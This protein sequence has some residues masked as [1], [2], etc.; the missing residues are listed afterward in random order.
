MAKKRK[1]KFVSQAP[2]QKD[3]G[4]RFTT[5]F[6]KDGRRPYLGKGLPEQEARRLAEGLVEEAEIREVISADSG[7]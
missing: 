5:H 2:L 6:V 3:D 7:Q 4:S 1:K